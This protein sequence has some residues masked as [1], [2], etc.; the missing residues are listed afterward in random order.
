MSVLEFKNRIQMIKEFATKL[1][2]ET[3]PQNDQKV[4]IKVYAHTLK[5]NLSDHMLKDIICG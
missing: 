5:I 1:N 3:I 2:S 4:I